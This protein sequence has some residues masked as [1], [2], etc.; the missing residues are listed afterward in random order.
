MK[1]LVALVMMA[2]LVPAV[3]YAKNPCKDDKVKFCKDVK[4]S[5]G[6]VN[7]CLREHAA[8]VSAACKEQL[9]KPKEGKPDK[10]ETKT[11]G[12]EAGDTTKSENAAKKPEDTKPADGAKATETPPAETKPAETAPAE[13][14]AAPVTP[15]T[16]GE[17]KP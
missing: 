16:P 1:K 14:P 8:E 3:A 7:D 17:T 15:V 2:F 6:K 12:K 11:K 4:A 5:G 13:T 10:A 9:A